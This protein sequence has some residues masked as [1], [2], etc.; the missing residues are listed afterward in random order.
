M[1][2]EFSPIVPS[3]F[4]GSV[5]LISGDNTQLLPNISY[6]ISRERNSI[7]DVFEIRFEYHCS[8]FRQALILEEYLAVGY[9]EYFYLYDLKQDL[10]LV[11]IK[12]DGY[13]SHLYFDSDSF[14][15]SSAGSI[16]CVTKKGS[17]L[18]I[19][20]NFGVDGVLIKNFDNGKIFGTGE[21]DPPGG[22][23]DFILDKVDGRLL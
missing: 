7:L 16:Y 3:D 17:I 2:F 11:A 5:K 18:W 20:T 21:W 19:N 14:Y 4:R 6:L 1:D 10:N 13:F 12:M 8:P 15:I 9:E 22:W 23:R